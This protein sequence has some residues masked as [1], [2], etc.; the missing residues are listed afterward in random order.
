VV[1][2]SK[3]RRFVVPLL[4]SRSV[5]MIRI[6]HRLLY[7]YP[8]QRYPFPP[9]PFPEM[10][11]LVMKR[12]YSS[13]SS[14]SKVTHLPHFSRFLTRILYRRLS[15]AKKINTARFKATR[16]S[17]TMLQSPPLGASSLRIVGRQQKRERRRKIN[18]PPVR[19]FYKKKNDD[20]DEKRRGKGKKT[21]EY[22]EIRPGQGPNA[23][24]FPE[25]CEYL[26][27]SNSNSSTVEGI[28]PLAFRERYYDDDD[29]KGMK[30]L[31]WNKTRSD[32]K[33][34]TYY[35]DLRQ[36]LEHEDWQV[37]PF[38]GGCAYQ[39]PSKNAFRRISGY[40]LSIKGGLKERDEEFVKK[41]FETCNEDLSA[42]VIV[43]DL[44]GGS[45]KKAQSSEASNRGVI[46]RSDSFAVRACY[47]LVQAG[48]SDVK[49]IEGGFPGLIDDA[50]LPYTSEK[51]SD[52]LRNQS[53]GNRKLLMYAKLLPDPTILPGVLIQGG[54]FLIFGLAFY[55]VNGF[56]DYLSENVPAACSFLPIKSCF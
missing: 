38:Q 6:P 49:F 15:S 37:P 50:G 11:V 44:K 3:S 7:S 4:L 16:M 18:P 26:V 27:S 52:L 21:T 56:G 48:F 31:L 53:E 17:T 28:S 35:L 12:A 25:I 22:D 32:S 14:P 8:S 36:P 43:C 55:N 46:D 2:I 19:A 47:E 33:K 13:S 23:P 41:V 20:E 1:E 42:T 30:G 10:V 9:F 24:K 29:E 51:F 39:I 54:V 34:N 5:S 45:I 40:A